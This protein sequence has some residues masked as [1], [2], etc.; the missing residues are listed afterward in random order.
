MYNEKD[1]IELDER[2]RKIIFSLPIVDNI[3]EFILLKYV[4]TYQN[5]IEEIKN[6]PYI[7]AYELP[8]NPEI[9]GAGRV[10]LILA[11]ID[12]FNPVFKV[13][14]FKYLQEKSGSTSRTSR[15]KKRRK[16]EEQAFMNTIHVKRLFKEYTV[17]FSYFTNESLFRVGETSYSEFYLEEWENIQLLYPFYNLT[18]E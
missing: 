2:W 4:L 13:V 5:Q 16:L 10:D 12:D 7:F 8:I 3:H 11:K 15:R 6:Y 9:S 1:L 18:N 17:T 14:E